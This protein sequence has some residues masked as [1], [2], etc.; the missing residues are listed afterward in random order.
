MVFFIT[1]TVHARFR[2]RVEGHRHSHTGHGA[3]AA[4][5]VLAVS[6]G[7]AGGQLETAAIRRYYGREL[8]DNMRPDAAGTKLDAHNFLYFVW[9]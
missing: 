6:E 8:C 3:R 1:E 2:N 9:W 4:M 7:P 5:E